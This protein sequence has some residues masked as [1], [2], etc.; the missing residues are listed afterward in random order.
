[1]QFKTKCAEVAVVMRGLKG[2][3]KGTLGSLLC[4]IFANQ[5]LHISSRKHLVGTFNRHLM[6]CC[7]LFADEAFWAGYH[8]GAAELQRMVTELTLSIEPKG[9]YSYQAINNLSIIMAS[10]EDWVLSVSWGYDYALM[11][12]LTFQTSAAAIGR[13]S[14]RCKLSFIRTAARSA[15]SGRYARRRSWRLASPRRRPAD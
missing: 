1:M 3:G 2:T 10:N 4:R 11:L 8:A 6:N 15:F 13:T 7:F 12:F 5:A 14:M 9:I